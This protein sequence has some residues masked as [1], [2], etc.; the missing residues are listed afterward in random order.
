MNGSPVSEVVLS[1]D[2]PKVKDKFIFIGDQK[3]YVRGVTYGTFRTDEEENNYPHPEV[4]ERDFACMEANGINALR[5]YTVPPEWLLDAA[6]R[7]GLRVIVG[8]AW[9]QHIAFLDDKQ[10]VKAIEKR[11]RAGVKAC[12]GHPAVLCYVIGNEIP[13]SIVRWYGA[14]RV[15]RFIERLYWVAKG[16]DPDGLVTYV[17]YPTTEYLQLHF[18]DF[19]C[20]NVYLESQERLE[21]YLARLQ[22]IAGDR[23]AR[24]TQ[25]QRTFN[26]C[27]V[28]RWSRKKSL[29]PR[30]TRY[31]S[32]LTGG[33]TP[34]LIWVSGSSRR[35]GN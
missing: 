2:R 6:N 9:E 18:I 33:P 27:S 12:A 21:A 14:R 26:V 32:G 22:N 34:A 10:R 24:G 7:H 35:K 4:V 17:N 30:L 28:Y 29:K 20:F 23:L 16:E 25:A 3:F 15:E 31:W 19:A 8:L 11:V 5:T 1:G 13:A